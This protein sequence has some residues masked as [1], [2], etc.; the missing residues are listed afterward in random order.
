MSLIACG[1]NHQTASVAIRERIAFLPEF[2]E[3]PLRALVGQGLAHEAAILSTCNRTEIYCAAAQPTDI[4][5]WLGK[6]HPEITPYLYLHQDQAAV[7]HMLR[8]AS[9][10]DSQILGE[11]QILG[12]MKQAF[13]IAQAAGT[14]GS[15]LQRLFQH[16]F[17]VTKT[18]RTDTRIG[19]NPV[20]IAFA[21]VNLAKR[22]FTD[23]AQTHVLLIGA[24]NTIDL[25]M[26]HLSSHGVRNFTIANRTFVRAEKLAQ[27]YTGKAIVLKN[28]SAALAHAD[29]VI[30]ATASALPLLGKGMVETSLKERKHRPL[31][32]VDLSVPRNIECE[33]EKLSDVYLYTIDDLK[34]L[35]QENLNTRREA[36]EH[37]EKIIDFQAEHFMRSS[38]ALD[39]VPMIRAYREKVEAM[40]YE[41]LMRA[42]GRI[43]QGADPE[44]ML[45]Q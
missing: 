35:I 44:E 38:R 10:L 36:A 43:K 45:I 6:T 18:V 20:S 19:A 2:M 34:G 27:K 9:G 32:M 5:H 21:A 33:I 4:T 31:L 11:P 17:A 12:Q 42:L 39:A 1:I 29:I 14:L 25:V 3:E 41:E 7:R 8:V 26:Q 22:I 13:S 16:V 30:T 37:A 40:R 28:I 23:L 15:K 24:G